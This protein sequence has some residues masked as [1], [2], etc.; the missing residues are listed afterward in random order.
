MSITAQNYFDEYLQ[1]RLGKHLRGT[2]WD[3]DQHSH[4]QAGGVHAAAPVTVPG[5]ADQMSKVPAKLRVFE[6][7]TPLKAKDAQT[8]P[9]GAANLAAAVAVMPA[10]TTRPTF[11]GKKGSKA[12]EAFESLADMQEELNKAVVGNGQVDMVRFGAAVKRFKKAAVTLSSFQY[13]AKLAA[14]RASVGDPN[15]QPGNP[16]PP[17]LVG[18]REHYQQIFDDITQAHT[19]LVTGQKTQTWVVREFGQSVPPIPG[20]A[21]NPGTP[22]NTTPFEPWAHALPPFKKKTRGKTEAL[23]NALGQM[24]LEINRAAASG[25]PLDTRLYDL[26]RESAV[27][28]LKAMVAPINHMR[29]QEAA[30]VTLSP[31]W[32]ATVAQ[33]AYD[34]YSGIL[35]RLDS[36]AGLDPQNPGSPQLVWTV[37]EDGEPLPD[38]PGLDQGQTQ[39]PPTT[40][41]AFEA[42]STAVQAAPAVGTPNATGL[43]QWGG[44]PDKETGLLAGPVN[45]LTTW[46]P[47]PRA[48][49]EA[50]LR[51]DLNHS[52]PFGMDY[53]GPT[54]K[55]LTIYHKTSS[56]Y[57]DGITKNGLRW[58]GTN[59]YGAGVYT[60]A[61][62]KDA[63][64][65]G[66]AMVMLEVH[67]GR[68]ISHSDACTLRDNWPGDRTGLDSA[69][70]LRR[71]CLDAGYSSMA[72]DYGCPAMV[73]FD[74]AR[75]RPIGAY[76]GGSGYIYTNPK[77]MTTVDGQTVQSPAVPSS[78]GGRVK[79]T[80]P[81]G[82]TYDGPEL[83]TDDDSTLGWRNKP[84]SSHPNAAKNRTVSA[85]PE[86]TLSDKAHQSLQRL[87]QLRNQNP[88]LN[89]Q[90]QNNIGEA[91]RV[92]RLLLPIRVTDGNTLL[93]IVRAG[94][95]LSRDKMPVVS[96]ALRQSSDPDMQ[97]AAD[98][99]DRVA[100]SPLF[101]PSDQALGLTDKV[102]LAFGPPMRNLRMSGYGGNADVVMVARR[103][104][105]S[106]P[107]V[108]GNPASISSY[109]DGRP[110]A[111]ADAQA[112]RDNT[113]DYESFC[114]VFA[115]RL[116]M[117]MIQPWVDSNGQFSD[118]HTPR[119]G[120][121][122]SPDDYVNNAPM[123]T[124]ETPELY[125][126]DALG[127]S[128]FSQ[129]YIGKSA[130]VDVQVGTPPTPA[131]PAVP[132]TPAKT[133]PTVTRDNAG[134]QDTFVADKYV[135]FE[136]QQTITNPDGSTRPGKLWNAA[137]G[138]SMDD[139]EVAQ[140]G[141]NWWD[142]PTRQTMR[143]VQMPLQLN[144]AGQWEFVTAPA[145]PGSPAVPAQPGHTR[146]V[147]KPA[148]AFFK[149]LFQQMKL[150]IEVVET[151]DR[152]TPHDSDQYNRNPYQGMMYRVNSI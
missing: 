66:D 116:A 63:G 21:N 36:A 68:T 125:V 58:G 1:R 52:E 23:Y 127:L 139:Q 108:E 69:E 152:Q 150:D 91:R 101:N 12:E 16:L 147:S 94:G 133:T 28:R 6:P 103:G 128:D 17:Q 47:N 44:V 146:T 81:D 7:P 20:L 29:Q 11:T 115:Q 2:R 114:E 142:G 80:A 112:W 30:G 111:A 109:A 13:G 78:S 132:P 119:A 134:K 62:W 3:H 25:Q 136:R 53:Q 96:A 113:F 135:Q 98:N 84:P 51:P 121:I 67:T 48:Y 82:S 138:R 57:V 86:V 4:A 100:Q 75:I 74:P 92:A 83:S 129:V 38:I 90:F 32:N 50:R 71:A 14:W 140:A 110:G 104:V 120:A 27:E 59:V 19:N 41:V 10:S 93:N 124:S 97:A 72:I 77:P 37:H 89:R 151:H 76:G 26:A 55:V 148:A 61:N 87:Q 8:N 15:A 34:H 45:P 31:N 9:V 106:R 149:Q 102:Q 122:S 145:T 65:H 35:S 5:L 24:Q 43:R 130:T 143:Q 49:D 70:V 64:G 99:L 33:A 137:A 105:L 22:V 39:R 95:L 85:P 144:A 79:L 88:Q 107:G 40:P 18:P 42:D 60:Y 118:T 123:F 117:G 56:S 46:Q 126:R 141:A 131:R 73:V 54:G